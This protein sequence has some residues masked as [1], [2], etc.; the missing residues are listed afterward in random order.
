MEGPTGLVFA[1]DDLKALSELDQ[2]VRN[3]A[4][5]DGDRTSGA[6]DFAF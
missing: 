3:R 2:L 1:S 4:G 5:A 6:N